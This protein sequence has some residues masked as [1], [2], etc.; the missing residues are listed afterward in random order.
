M[1]PLAFADARKALEDEG[2]LVIP[3]DRVVTFTQTHAIDGG[4]WALLQHSDGYLDHIDKYLAKSI[5]LAIVDHPMHQ[6]LRTLKSYEGHRRFE[7]RV[8][9]AF[10]LV[11]DTD[12]Q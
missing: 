11:E 5:G 1:R 3:K 8:T 4:E 6:P 12:T 10:P 7:Q 9:V 2:Y